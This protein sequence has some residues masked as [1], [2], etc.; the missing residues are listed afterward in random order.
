M[1]C[2]SLCCW[3]WCGSGV[4]SV[5]WCVVWHAENLPCAD[6]SGL[7]VY[8]RSVSVY[9]QHI[10]MYKT[11][12]RV[13]G[14][15][16]AVLNVHTEARDLEEEGGERGREEEIQKKISHMHQSFAGSD[17]LIE[18]IESLTQHKHTHTHTETQIQN[19]NTNTK[20]TATMTFQACSKEIR[21]VQT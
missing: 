20:T 15:H 6:S 7:R 3:L 9:Q 4:V 13:A 17:H 12:G 8:I 11:C 10:D 21:R 14:T 19:T 2:G 1:C 18:L 16:G 5:V